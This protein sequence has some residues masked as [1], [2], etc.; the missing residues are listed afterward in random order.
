MLVEGCDLLGDGL[1]DVFDHC[2]DFLQFWWAQWV[3][4][5]IECDIELVDKLF[6][7][8]FLDVGEVIKWAYQVLFEEVRSILQD[9]VV[10]SYA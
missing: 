3:I 8:T 10:R 4:R 2:L 1:F 5:T 7:G 6:L 9:F